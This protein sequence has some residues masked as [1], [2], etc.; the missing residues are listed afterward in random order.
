MLTEFMKT[1]RKHQNDLATKYHGKFVLISSNGVLGTF[2]SR[3][4]AYWGA[5]DDQ[6]L[7]P[8]EFLIRECVFPEEER[9]VVFYTNV[10]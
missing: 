8:G 5:I 6:N 4:D 9:P 1:Y 2:P 7:V 3:T 10:K